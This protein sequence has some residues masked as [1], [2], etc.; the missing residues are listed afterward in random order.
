MSEA[1]DLNPMNANKRTKMRKKW[2]FTLVALG[3]SS[4]GR[5]ADSIERS[6]VG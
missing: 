3:D 4:V 6:L 5:L 1:G 2:A